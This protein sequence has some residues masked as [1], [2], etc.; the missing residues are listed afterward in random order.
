MVTKFL[1]SRVNKRAC[2]GPLARSL[3]N[4]S[5]LGSWCLLFRSLCSSHH[6]ALFVKQA[7]LCQPLPYPKRDPQKNSIPALLN[8]LV[9]VCDDL[10]LAILACLSDFACYHIYLLACITGV[11]SVAMLGLTLVPKI[12]HNWRRL[13][14]ALV[15]C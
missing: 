2:T 15:I 13:F 9:V 7:T 11:L 3:A 4:H 8:S 5:N 1:S 10:T 12:W 6:R 14:S